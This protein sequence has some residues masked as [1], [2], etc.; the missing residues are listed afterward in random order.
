MFVVQG[1]MIGLVGTVAG[2]AL[3]WLL[4]L[5]VPSHRA[6]HR[7]RCSACNS[8]MQVVYLMSDLPREVQHRDV[9]Q[10]CRR[11][12]CCCAALATIYPAW[13]ASRTLPAEALRHE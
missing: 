7:K 1:A 3:G 9:L 4:A 12:A 11:G 13:R 10:V 5:N 6:R 2:A 8:S